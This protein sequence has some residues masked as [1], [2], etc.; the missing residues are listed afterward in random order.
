MPTERT[1]RDNR[2]RFFP[3]GLDSHAFIEGWG[4]TRRA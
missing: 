1:L 3:R 2:I 4:F